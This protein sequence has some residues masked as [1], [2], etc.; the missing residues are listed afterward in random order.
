MLEET[1]NNFCHS[2]LTISCCYSERRKNEPFSSFGRTWGG[3]T[4]AVQI[5]G[6]RKN[7]GEKRVKAKI[8]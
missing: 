1:E 6:I 2:Y 3:M 5:E 8:R 4:Q 7:A